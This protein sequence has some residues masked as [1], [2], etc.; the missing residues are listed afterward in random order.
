VV[1]FQ[2][3]AKFFLFSKAIRPTSKS[4]QS[5]VQCEGTH[6]HPSDVRSRKVDLHLHCSIY[7]YGVMLNKHKGYFAEHVD[8]R[9]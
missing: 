8:K 4:I 5:P 3:G 6:E 1:G 7:F 2:A 9:R